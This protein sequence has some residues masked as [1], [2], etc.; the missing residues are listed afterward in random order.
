MRFRTAVALAALAALAIVGWAATP[1]TASAQQQAAPSGAGALPI[2]YVEAMRIELG[3]K[4]E[5][6]GNVG[7]EFRAQGAEPRLV[8]VD[9]IPKMKADEIA[10]DLYKQLTL[11]AGTK[12]KVKQG[13]DRVTIQK[14]DKK[15]PNFSLKITNQTVLGV[16]FLIAKD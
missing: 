14:A 10:R 12:F 5:Y 13:G 2:I 8:S 15:G 1:G 9:V 3:G 16:S 6:T 11:A 7:L 4:A